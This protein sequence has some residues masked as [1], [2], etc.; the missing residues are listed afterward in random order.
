[1]T[2]KD[3]NAVRHE[4]GGGARQNHMVNSNKR[5]N[6]RDDGGGAYAKHAKPEIREDEEVYACRDDENNNI[7]TP[8]VVLGVKES[9]KSKTQPRKEL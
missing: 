6:R 7:W 1:M 9:R 4:E 2:T 3:Y 5:G 8:G